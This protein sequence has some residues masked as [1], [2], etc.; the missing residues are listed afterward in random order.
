MEDMQDL[1]RREKLANIAKLE[2]E[3]RSIEFNN[4]LNLAKL[5]LSAFTV[6]IALI[7]GLDKLMG[8]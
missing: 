1:E 6:A 7:V 5:G 3:T 8:P 2:A 4:W